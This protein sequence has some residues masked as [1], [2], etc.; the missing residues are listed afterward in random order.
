MALLELKGI[1]KSFRRNKK[2]TLAVKNLSLTIDYGECLGLVGE[3]GCGKSTTAGIIARLVKEDRGTVEFNG[4]IISGG[5]YLKPA[6][7]H[8]QMIFQNPQDSFDPRDTLLDSVI[9]GAKSY[10]L[11]DREE[12]KKRAFDMLDYTGLKMS[13]ADIRTSE[14]SGGECQRAAIARAIICQ[15]K[16]LIC[17]EATS[18]LDVLV[19]AQIVD[20]LK[21]L[22][23]EKRM[24]ILFITHDIPLAAALCDRIA[25]MYNGE[26]VEEGATKQVL[27]APVHFQTKKLISAV[28]PAAGGMY[29]KISKE[30][31]N[32]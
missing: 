29:G 11:W 3:S 17:D 31:N 13:Y 7:R 28:M 9:Q 22:K 4:H 25:V 20:L 14:L 30:N 21:R 23:A 24:A 2:E 6:G 15:P 27:K 12:L 10:K 18:S 26:I 1:N 8:M 5:A 16:L 19:Q 32:E